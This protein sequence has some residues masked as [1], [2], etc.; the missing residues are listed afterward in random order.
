MVGRMFWCCYCS[1]FT[2]VYENLQELIKSCSKDHASELNRFKGDVINI[3][4]E[5]F[6]SACDKLKPKGNGVQKLFFQLIGPVF[7]ILVF[8]IALGSN[9]DIS[10]CVVHGTLFLLFCFAYG[11]Y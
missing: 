8:S 4:W 9:I 7:I 6:T 2:I 11:P 5:H 1:F 3:P 10:T